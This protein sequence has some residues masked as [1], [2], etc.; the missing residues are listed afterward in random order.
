MEIYV[1]RVEW[2]EAER[3]LASG[4][5]EATWG[6]AVAGEEQWI[7]RDDAIPEWG[8]L[9]SAATCLYQTLPEDRPE[10]ETLHQ[11]VRRTL[12]QRPEHNAL[13]QTVGLTLL[14]PDQAAYVATLAAGL[15]RA[16]L[17]QAILVHGDPDDLEDLR[18]YAEDLDVEEPVD[19]FLA[20]LDRWV[21]VCKKAAE[22][23]QGL[24]VVA[25]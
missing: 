7:H 8:R 13:G 16:R 25:G 18:D 1:S 22:A 3:R 19:V 6:D 2:K 9:W 20:Y 14:V 24:V 12:D 4:R 21:A 5:F 10:L 23:G 15:D 17:R 11:V